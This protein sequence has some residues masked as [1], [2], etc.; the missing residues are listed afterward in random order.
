MQVRWSCKIRR[1]YRI[2]VDT[3]AAVGLV[4]AIGVDI[5]VDVSL[6]VDVGAGVDI[7]PHPV[8]NAVCRMLFSPVR[9]LCL[10]CYLVDCS[11]AL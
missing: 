3:D 11:I 2:G 9:S 10:P 4:I 8:L 6:C 5:A 1:R 7:S